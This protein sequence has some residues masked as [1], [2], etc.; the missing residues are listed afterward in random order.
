MRHATFALVLFPMAVGAAERTLHFSHPASGITAVELAVGASDVEVIGTDGDEINAEVVI[1]GTRWQ[2]QKLDIASRIVGKTLTLSLEPA[3]YSKGKAD[4]HW[5]L[6]LPKRLALDV[7]AGVGDIRIKGLS[8]DLE[9]EVGVGDILVEDFS[10]NFEAKTGVGD[11]ELT[12]P[13]S[14]VGHLDLVT[15][16][17]SINVRKPQGKEEGRGLISQT[18]SEEGPGKARIR[19]TTGVGDITVRLQ[20]Q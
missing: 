7:E 13:W 9:L 14:A 19:V 6:Q 1:S 20:N 12:V 5:Q 3:K 15:G 18:Y 17:G 16:V 4:K 10:G 2:V 11:V 8:G